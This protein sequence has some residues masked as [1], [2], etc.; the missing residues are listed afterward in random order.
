[1]V[2]LSSMITTIFTRLSPRQEANFGA[3]AGRLLLRGSERE[4]AMKNSKFFGVRSSIALVF[5]SPV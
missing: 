2:T 5:Y 4:R 1:M 3:N